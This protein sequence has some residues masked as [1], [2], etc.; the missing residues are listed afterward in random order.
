MGLGMA[1]A[2]HLVASTRGRDR[3]LIWPE[4]AGWLWGRLRDG[5]PD[6]LSCLVMPDHLHL[7]TPPGGRPRLR[8]ILASFTVRFGVRFDVLDP[9]PANSPAIAG[10]AIRYG[11]FNPVRGGLT[12]DPWE[13]PWSTLRDLVGAAVPVWTPLSRVASTLGLSPSAALR[14][15]TRLADHRPRLPK[16]VR[17]AAMSIDAV[18][19]A[20][21]SALRL[22]RGDELTKPLPRKLIV[23]ACFEVGSPSPGALAARLGCSVRS[24]HRDRTPR[25]VELDAVLLCLSDDRLRIGSQ[26]LVLRQQGR[27]AG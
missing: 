9:E 25:Q 24:I 27:R 13:W 11:L 6:A 17:V 7:V 23:Q 16:P 18:C 2:E 1:I 20:V 10:R 12:D 3:S 14:G 8:R 5:F 22:T 19:G 15:L 21:R 26:D 4:R